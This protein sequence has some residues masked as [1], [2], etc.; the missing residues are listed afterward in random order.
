MSAA[1]QTCSLLK[2][3]E[4]QKQQQADD[5]FSR[6]A[7]NVISKNNTTNSAIKKKLDQHNKDL[8]AERRAKAAT[9]VYDIDTKGQLAK[10]PACLKLIDTSSEASLRQLESDLGLERNSLHPEHFANEK[11]GYRA[12]VFYD[13]RDE[14]YVVTFRGTN[15]NN[16]IDWKNNINN[17]L[18]DAT[19]RDAPSYF[20]AKNLGGLLKN[21]KP[22]VEF[23]GHSKGG[24]EV[25]EALSNAPNSI[26]IVFNPAGPSPRITDVAKSNI[27]QRTQN[28][29]VGGEM[30]NLMQNETNPET[31][32]ENMKWLRNQ[33]DK[34]LYKSAKAVKITERDND[35]IKEKEELEKKTGYIFNSSDEEKAAKAKL[36]KIEA[37]YKRERQAFI[38]QLDTKIAE[39]E[40][41]L[42]Q[43]NAGRVV[44]N[45]TPPFARS[46]GEERIVGGDP[47]RSGTP[48]IG[49]LSDHTMVNMN[50][51]LKGQIAKDHK[52]IEKTVR[53]LD[54]NFNKKLNVCT[55][56]I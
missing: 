38:N 33:V 18:P 29:Q 15:K 24:G 14:K 39:K 36:D 48:N 19:E 50:E 27:A 12:A 35:T 11:N 21:S 20:A 31:T 7:G 30:L 46:L 37:D 47:D 16:L 1:C 54:P 40:A 52:E 32:I 3:A 53:G 8:K 5:C 34:G 55:T 49:A 13:Q 56:G 45:W 6:I 4:C 23:T 17:Q 2:N 26:A 9:A 43:R 51:A 28:Y 41:W 22:A 25:Y 42:N 10:P 44:P